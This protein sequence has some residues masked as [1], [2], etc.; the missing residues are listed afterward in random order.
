[1]NKK[2]NNLKNN[3]S[4]VGVG[5]AIG[6]AIGVATNEPTWIALGVA[7]GRHLVGKTKKIIQRPHHYIHIY[8]RGTSSI[9]ATLNK[10]IVN[11][12][13]WHFFTCHELPRNMPCFQLGLGQSL[14]QTYD[15][16]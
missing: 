2:F 3:G 4:W 5:T 15:I 7:I 13:A 11:I 12:V 10:A 8:Y 6:V 14:G 1:M 16:I 9:G